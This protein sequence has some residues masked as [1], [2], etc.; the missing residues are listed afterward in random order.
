M[1]FLFIQYEYIA[2]E[3]RKIVAFKGMIRNF[4]NM[5]AVHIEGLR[6]SPHMLNDTL[7]SCQCPYQLIFS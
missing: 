7:F 6:V 1:K 2:G 4:F 5:V 3:F